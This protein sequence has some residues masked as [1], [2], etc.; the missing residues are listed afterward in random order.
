MADGITFSSL[1]SSVSGLGSNSG[2]LA[3]TSMTGRT[4][5]VIPLVNYND[6]S[7]HIFFGNAIR[8]YRISDKYIRDN[9]PIGLSGLSASNILQ[10]AAVGPKAVFQV[11]EFRKKADGFTLFLLDRL[12]VSGSSSGNMNTDA[13]VTVMAKNS[14]GENVPLIAVYRNALNSIT[15]GQ[16]GMVESISCRAVL[17]EEQQ[18]NTVDQTS[19]TAVE[20]IGT[21]TGAYRYVKEYGPTAEQ[22]I[23][24]AEKLENMLPEALFSGDD[25]DV[26]KRLLA[27]FGDE[28][29]EIKAF[30]NQIPDVK[31]ISYDKI[32]R[33][34]NKF[35]PTFLSQFG[36]DVYESARRANFANSL[37]N[38]SP[39]GYS[40]QQITHE[41]WNRI[42][43]NVMHILKAKGTREAVESI[44]RIYGVDTNFLKTNEYSIFYKPI[45]TRE[46]EEVDTPTLFSDGTVFVETTANA[47]TGS[48]RVFDLPA[49]ADFTLEMRVSATAVPTTGHTLL[50]HPLYSIE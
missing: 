14:H 50:V 22:S 41:V 25:N 32:D 24:R 49:S 9:Y 34:P 2:N 38:V 10:N 26:L 42:L 31:R 23:T 13:N 16:T 5:R 19:G 8:R 48:S 40:T 37:T 18:L 17:Y 12:G 20:I 3:D 35:L 46:I 27:G 47:A 1:L 15:G 30:A 4:A 45:R 6:F 7:N 28:L 29:D 39:S 36:V 21:S 33:T 44:G 11:D 43:N